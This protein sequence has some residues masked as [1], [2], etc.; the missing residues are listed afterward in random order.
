MKVKKK[1][2]L[3]AGFTIGTLLFAS[4]ALADIAS[5]SGY[6]QLK[7]GLKVTAEKM[8]SE[9]D[10]YTMDMSFVIK[11]NGKVLEADNQIEK[12]DRKNKAV[13]SLHT[14]EGVRSSYYPN[15]RYQDSKTEIYYGSGNDKKVYVTDYS[16]ER[17]LSQFDNP[18]ELDEAPDVER[19]VDAVVGSLKDHVIV[20]DNSDG[21]KELSGSLSE[22]QIPA[23]VN[24]LAS[25]QL[26]Q[27]FGNRNGSAT[28]WPQLKE[29]ISFEEVTGTAALDSDGV[30]NSLLATVKINGKD[31]QGQDHEISVEIL[32]E[33]LD[34]NSTTVSKPDLTG[35]EVVKQV[36]KNV[37]PELTNPQKFIGT[38]KND[39][40]TEKDGKFAKAGERILE[41]T[42]IDGEK[43][44]GN[45]HE[46]YKDGFADS[47]NTVTDFSFTGTFDSRSSR[48]AR[49]E[50]TT[51]EGAKLQGYLYFEEA[52]GKINFFFSSNNY[53]YGPMFDSSFSLV[54]E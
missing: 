27:E 9:Y 36:Y 33:L 13:E 18:F 43:V 25:L 19:I 7:D 22:M 12:F 11:D 46:E 10:N 23:L 5:K 51:N 20:K 3:I 34:V 38:Y 39:I 2:A 47:A 44:S 40:L 28:D 48:D 26:K 17:K 32:A 14:S 41:I 42:Q 31:V 6:E 53:S 35:K 1:T 8:N 16:E 50:V 30:M 49:F 54:L 29:D 15:Y 24:A 45:Y 4:T 52:L 21:S 37:G